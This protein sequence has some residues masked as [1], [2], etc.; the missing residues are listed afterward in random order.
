M[1]TYYLITKPVEF[2]WIDISLPSFDFRFLRTFWSKHVAKHICIRQNLGWVRTFNLI[3]PI[4]Y[5]FIICLD[6]IYILYVDNSTCL[7]V[8]CSNRYM[9]QD[10][11]QTRSQHSNNTIRD[12]LFSCDFTGNNYSWFWVDFTLNCD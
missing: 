7:A 12:L 9:R 8:S 3:S 2:I 4:K 1:T 5:C 6:D 10:I 11:N